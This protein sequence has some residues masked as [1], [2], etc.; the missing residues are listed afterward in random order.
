MKW[1]SFLAFSHQNICYTFMDSCCVWCL[2]NYFFLSKRVNFGSIVEISFTSFF[3]KT[4]WNSFQMYQKI[5]KI[6]PVRTRNIW[7]SRQHSVEKETHSTSEVNWTFVRTGKTS[8]SPKLIPGFVALKIHNTKFCNIY[9]T[10]FNGLISEPQCNA[11][12]WLYSVFNIIDWNVFL[13]RSAL[14]CFTNLINMS[15]NGW[16]SYL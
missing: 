12:K 15:R 14:I 3:L 6:E 8:I 10:E 11:L 13:G 5:H 2:G 4:C 1:R 9:S 16:S 7:Q